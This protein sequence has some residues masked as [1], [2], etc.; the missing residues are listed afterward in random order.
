MANVKFMGNPI[1]TVG[2]LPEVGKEAP[3]F[4][5]TKQ[6]LSDISLHDLKG[7]RV[8]LNVF[9][10]IDTDVCAMSVRRFNNEVANLPNTVVL[11]VSMDLPF[12]AGRFCAANG[13]DNVITASGFRSD[14]GKSYGFEIAEG[15]LRDLY[16]RGL[17]IL[18]KDGKVMGTSLC[19]EI[20]NEPDY[21]YAKSLLA[22]E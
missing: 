16:A 8:V 6:D 10:S 4:A 18:D 3:F 19:E 9:P 15:P 22:T 20:S 5:L 2:E 14:F 13:I 17:V 11:C 12:A 1:Q 7:K 21:E